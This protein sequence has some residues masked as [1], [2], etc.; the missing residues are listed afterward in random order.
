RL[1][2]IDLSAGAQPMSNDDGS[3]AI[4]FNGEIFNYVELRQDLIA[5]GHKFRTAS[6]TEV[7]IRLYEA[8]GPA[9]VENLNRA[10]AFPILDSRR[11]PMVLARERMGVRPPLHT[12]SGGTLYFA[13]EVK[14][15]LEVPGVAA[16]LDPVA[17]DQIFTL[18]FPLAPRTIFKGVSELPPA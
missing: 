10:L 8:M 13:A 4:T 3:V 18:W 15:L 5:R 9:C 14:A 1:S 11:R 16:E 6:D 2:I 17:L 12:Q 7:I